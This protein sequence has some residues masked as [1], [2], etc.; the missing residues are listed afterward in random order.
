MR[1]EPASNLFSLFTTCLALEDDSVVFFIPC[2]LHQIKKWFVKPFLIPQIP[3]KRNI[4]GSLNQDLIGSKMWS[5]TS[6][7][8]VALFQLSSQGLPPVNRTQPQQWPATSEITSTLVPASLQ[9]FA[10][11][12]LYCFR[13]YHLIQGIIYYKI[14]VILLLVKLCALPSI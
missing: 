13:I 4:Q 14:I 12:I 5:H 7:S 2:F 11:N 9:M 1:C 3:L 8:T 10:A 6:T